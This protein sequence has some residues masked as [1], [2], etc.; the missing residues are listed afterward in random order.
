MAWLAISCAG[1][2]ALA[3]EPF[4]SSR[5]AGPKARVVIVEDREATDSFRARAERIPAMVERGVTN[6]TSK[7]TSR[8]AWLSLVST[9]DVVGIKVY[10]VPG[11]NS[12]TRPAVARAVV[13][14]LLAAGLPP[15]QIIIWDKSE[16]DLRRAGYFEIG[17][18]LGVR[19]EASAS[20]GYDDASS[21][22]NS[23]IGSLVWGDH[24][25]ELTGPDIGKRSFVSKLVSQQ[26]TKIISLAPLL[27]HNSAGVSGNLYGLAVGSVDNTMR[28]ELDPG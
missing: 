2:A 4:T 19:V 3:A 26:I 17:D 23:I 27:N 11:P 6:L 12:G 24:E 18:E 7:A 28:F 22:T 10:S 1:L 14:S 9:Q 8:E 21:Y 25:F 20:A 15:K 5:P 13:E 16:R